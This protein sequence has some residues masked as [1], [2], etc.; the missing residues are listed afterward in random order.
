MSGLF[1]T[2]NSSSMALGAHSRAIETSGKNL[3]NVNNPNYARQRVVYG[4]RGTVE[5]PDGVQSLGLEVLAI[6]Q[7]RD[8]LLDRQLMREI[9]LSGSYEAEQQALQRAQA[10]LGQNIS[11]TTSVTGSDSGGLSAALDNFFNAF[12]SLAARPT[13]MGTRQTLLQQAAILTGSLQ[14][15]DARLVQVQSDINAEI[16]ADV[17]A[18]NTL[19]DTIAGLNAQIARFEISRPGAAVDLRD[20]RQARLEELAAILPVE[21]RD[22]GDGQ[23]ELVAKDAGNADI[24]LLTGPT[25]N[26]AVAFTGTALTGGS[27]ATAIALGGGSIQ[28]A[29]T[30]RDGAVQDLRDNLDLLAEQLVTSVNAAYNPSST[31]GADF[32]EPAGTTAA[33]IAVRSGLT[34]ASLVTGAGAAGDNSIAVAVASLA[35][36]NFSTGSGDLLDGTFGQFYA[37]TVSDLGQSLA[38]ATARASDQD[39][40]QQLV[41]NQRDTVSGVSLDE[42][43]ADLVKFQ[44][45]FQA[46][47]RVFSIVDE[48]LET[49]VTRL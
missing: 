2:L 41:R 40:I 45:A 29:L 43:M 21:V 3:A 37:R 16:G 8:V 5:T 17:T 26:G 4:D 27:P 44:R 39:K 18:V 47:S 49:I 28:G 7:L 23:V 32:F 25:V 13:D 46:S 12:Q 35:N 36:R 14:E 15:V 48:L 11:G 34:A 1:S 30:A 19:L 31:A 38:T 42:E 22:L 24:V 9:G 20:Q 6:R 33:T 10:G